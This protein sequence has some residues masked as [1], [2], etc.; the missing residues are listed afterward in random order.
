M[1]FE[2]DLLY[3]IDLLNPRSCHFHQKY[4]LQALC[5]PLA[6]HAPPALCAP[7]ALHAPLAF[8]A[9]LALRALQ[10]LH[11]LGCCLLIRYFH[12]L[13]RFR[14]RYFL[15]LRQFQMYCYS[16]LLDRVRYYLI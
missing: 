7:L 3:Q 2:L 8:H 10:S 9:P 6:L 14:F 13:I 15:L 1:P 16:Q 11:S 12:L 4:H 5:A